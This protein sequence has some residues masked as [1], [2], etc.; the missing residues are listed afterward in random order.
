MNLP[1]I[2]QPILQIEVPSLKKKY[3]FRPFLVKEE[4]LLLMAKDS[5]EESDILIAIKQIITNCSLDPNLKINN[6]AI[7]DLE[8]LFL[9]LRMNSVDNIIEL[10]Y[11]DDEDEKEYTFKIDL[12]EIN[13]FF[14]ENIDNKI[15]INN[16][17]GIIMKY[18]KASLYD[19]NEFLQIEDEYFFN[20]IIKCIDKIYYQDSVYDV[21]DYKKEQIEEFLENL[22]LKTFE[23]IKNFLNSTPTLKHDLNYTNSLGTERKIE[24]RTLSDFF[25]L[26]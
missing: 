22:D 1:K 26:R 11:I 15:K 21:N 25:M 24:L 14:P 7:F 8:Y 2:D 12:N 5:G 3:P 4:K 20:L 13:V 18:P 6:L 23:K 16:I 9:K 19:D 10:S 17:S